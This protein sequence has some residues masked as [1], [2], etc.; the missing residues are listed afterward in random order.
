MKKQLTSST[1]FNDWWEKRRQHL[2]LRPSD[3]HDY[4]RKGIQFM[5]DNPAC[6]LF[7]DLGMGKTVM[8]LTAATNRLKDGEAKKVLIVAPLKVANRTWPDEFKVWSHFCCWDYS[9]LTGDEEDRTAAMKSKAPIHIINIDKIAWLVMQWK[10]KWPYD[11]VIIDESDCVKD[12]TTTRFKAMK[13]IRKYT[14]YWIEMTATPAAESYLD[15][16]AQI[17]LIDMGRRLGK[18]VTNFR[19]KYA[20][21]NKWTKRWSMREGAEKALVDRIADV[22]MVMLAK[23]YLKI[24]EPA[25]STIPVFLDDNQINLYRKM[26]ETM[27]VEVVGEDGEMVEVEAETAAALTSKL[28]QLASGVLYN[29]RDVMVDG[30]LKRHRDVYRIHDHKLDALEALVETAQAERETLLVVYHF[31]SSLDRLTARFPQAVVMDKAGDAVTPWNQGKIPILLVHPQSAGHGLNLQKGGH[32][33]VFFDIPWSLRAY[34][35]VIGRLARQGQK[36][37]VRV[38]HLIAMGTADELVLERLKEKNDTQD[39]L[40]ER[41]KKIRD[42]IRA[43]LRRARLSQ[44]EIEDDEL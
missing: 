17:Y 28:L 37:V 39:W 8:S 25:F 14:K 13:S 3:L 19:E 4:Q 12:T 38:Y 18:N 31:K 24:K 6:G 1:C 2:M 43:K 40:F 42:R 10:S 23:D 41:I 20:T 33:M 44:I 16:F 21:Q 32:V 11:M 7:V 35:Q 15:L 9:L 22:S 27:I 30:A 29:T 5:M 26:E 36:F 34:K